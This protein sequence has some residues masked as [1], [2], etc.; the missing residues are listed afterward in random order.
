MKLKVKDLKGMILLEMA[1]VMQGENFWYHTTTIENATK[2]FQEGLK[3]N[4][5]P[6]FSQASL[7]YMVKAYRGIIPIF[8][9]KEPRRYD[10]NH[11][12]V[13]LRVDIQGMEKSLAAD[14]P[15]LLGSFGAYLADNERGI[16]FEE[17]DIRIPQK[18]REKEELSFRSFLPGGGACLTSIAL[19]KTAGLLQ[20]VPP[21]RIMKME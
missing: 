21:E 3:V 17:D 14:I 20:N 15:T 19:T 7:E 6:N 1:K 2:I 9:S 4:S 5:S 13:L 16:Y 10:N 12:S 8:L 11:Q 18:L